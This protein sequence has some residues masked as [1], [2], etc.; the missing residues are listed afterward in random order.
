MGVQQHEQDDWDKG[1]GGQHPGG[2]PL[3]QM[4][5]VKKCSIHEWVIIKCE[6]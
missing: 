1:R 4:T 6:N 2:Y 3:V 5:L